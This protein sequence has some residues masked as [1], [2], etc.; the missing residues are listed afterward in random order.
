MRKQEKKNKYLLL[1]SLL[2]LI[3]LG[4][5][6]LQANL[7]INGISRIG[8]INWNVHFEN[9]EA[10]EES[11]VTPTVAPEADPE[12]EVTDLT[13]EDGTAIAPNHLLAADS[14][15]TIK[16]RVGFKLDITNEDLAEA[17]NCEDQECEAKYDNLVNGTYTLRGLKTGTYDNEWNFTCDSEYDDGN[18]NYMSP[19]YQDNVD[20]IKE[21]FNYDTQPSI[22]YVNSSDFYCDVPGLD[23]GADARGYVCAYGDSW[24]CHVISDGSSYCNDL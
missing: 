7:T 15:E 5:A 6:L 19:Y 22:C 17:A 18:E 11:M 9:A 16:V 4:Y 23:A 12:D 2:L 1:G 24:V 14:S 21:A 13:Y 3:G 20:V 10:T 8:D